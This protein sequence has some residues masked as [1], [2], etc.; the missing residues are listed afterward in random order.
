MM[1]VIGA[2]RVLILVLAAAINIALSATVYLFVL[3]QM[4]SKQNE[5]KTLES[6]ATTLRSDIDR[7]K[8]QMSQIEQQ[9]AEFQNL[10][11]KG[12][13]S[14]QQRRQAEKIIEIIQQ[15]AGVKSAVAS[16]D[17]GVVEE[18][19]EARKAEYEILSSPV[20]ISLEAVDSSDIYR[21]IYLLEKYFPGHVSIKNIEIVRRGEV[22][23][24]VLRG[25]ASGENPALVGADLDFVWRTMIPKDMVIPA[26]Q[27]GSGG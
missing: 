19:E 13:F 14:D 6:Q 4:Q 18:N 25:I 20:K 11:A 3:P 15:R 26:Q 23:G 7:M 21:Y 1:N 22:T 8:V 16:I 9:Q 12:F 5:L 2:K 17:A 27:Q 10:K 24:P